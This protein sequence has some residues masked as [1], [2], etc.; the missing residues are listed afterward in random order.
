MLSHAGLGL[1]YRLLLEEGVGVMER[2]GYRYAVAADAPRLVRLLG[3]EA[4]RGLPLIVAYLD[5]RIVGAGSTQAV[6]VERKFRGHGIEQRLRTL[7][8]GVVAGGNA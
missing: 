1:E 3:P 2:I 7:V 4:S 6:A 8:R 5:N